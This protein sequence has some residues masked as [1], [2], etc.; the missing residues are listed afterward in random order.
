M[1]PS[2]FSPNLIRERDSMIP[3]NFVHL[4][5]TPDH[6]GPLFNLN[7]LDAKPL[8]A[9]NPS[10]YSISNPPLLSGDWND[11]LDYQAYLERANNDNR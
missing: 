5:Q 7:T 6:P 3:S 2:A 8:P 9:L 1:I 4:S 10:S 11:I